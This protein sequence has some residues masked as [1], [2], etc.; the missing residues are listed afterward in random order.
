VRLKAGIPGAVSTVIR[1]L[2][3]EACGVCRF[4]LFTVVTGKLAK[5]FVKKT[6]KK[7]D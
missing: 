4:V 2:I 5:I 1:G 3:H 6:R 7:Q